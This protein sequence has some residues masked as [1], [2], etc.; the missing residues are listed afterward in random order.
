M[1]E[2]SCKS[3]IDENK[4]C[5]IKGLKN[6]KLRVFASKEEVKASKHPERFEKIK[7]DNIQIKDYKNQNFDPIWKNIFDNYDEFYFLKESCPFVSDKG[8]KLGNKLKPFICLIFPVDFNL[9][10]KEIIY[11]QK[12]TDYIPCKAKN[13]YNFNEY[14]SNFK[15]TKEFLQ[16][17]LNTYY[18]QL[19]KEFPRAFK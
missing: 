9:T 8:C 7:L 5:C 11:N 16:K 19:K 4:D 2:N 18:N 1:L 14:L 10:K 13:N 12:E 3:C 6:Y 17:R 15:I